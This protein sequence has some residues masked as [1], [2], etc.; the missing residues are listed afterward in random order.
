MYVLC[1]TLRMFIIYEMVNVGDSCFMKFVVEHS[2]GIFRETHITRYCETP[3]PPSLPI[4]LITS[5]YLG[6]EPR[7]LLL[8]VGDK[9]GSE[10]VQ[11]IIPTPP[12][13]PPQRKQNNRIPDPTIDAC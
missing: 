8:S 6:K 10:R 7:L 4:D 1:L 9:S 12:S 11:E 5:G 3:P 13:F 2:S